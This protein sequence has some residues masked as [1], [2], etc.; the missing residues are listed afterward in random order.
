MNFISEINL[1]KKVNSILKPP[2]NLLVSIWSERYRKLS[3]ETSSEVGKWNTDRTVYQREPMDCISDPE[4]KYL[5]LKFPSQMGKSDIAL[6]I[7]GRFIHLEPCPILVVQPSDKDAE[8]FSQRFSYMIRDCDPLSKLISEPGSRKAKNKISY[9]TFPGGEI[10]FVGSNSPN[11]LSGKPIKLLLCDDIR[12]FP[13]SSGK[14]GDPVDLA[15][16]RT[17]TFFDSLIILSSSP[18]MKGRCRISEAYNLSDQRTY[19]MPCPGCG[20]EIL[21]KWKYLKFEKNKKGN[22]LIASIFYQCYFCNYK[23]DESQKQEMIEAGKWIRNA[24]HIKNSAGFWLTELYSPWVKWEEV[25]RSFLDAKKD[26]EKLKV[27]INTS[28][29]EEYQDRGDIPDWKYL[30]SRKDKYK[31]NEIPRQGLLLVGGADVQKNRIEIEIVIYGRKFESWSIDYRVLTGD[32]TQS[33]IWNLLNDILNE[34]FYHPAGK[35]IRIRRI[36]IDSGH[37]TTNVY[38]FGRKLGPDLVIVGKGMSHLNSIL[39]HPKKMDIDLGNRKI[40]GGV[41]LYGIGERIIKN[42]IY[43]HLRKESPKAGDPFPDGFFHFP[44]DYQEEYFKMLTAEQAKLY[45]TST[46]Y[47]T[48]YEKIRERNEALD[49]RVL[50]RAAASSLGMDSYSDLMWDRIENSLTNTPKTKKKSKTRKRGGFSIKF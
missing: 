13:R 11:N 5:I 28:F 24:K 4:I 33:D 44:Y 50:A 15:K 9:K 39:G 23:I 37:C 48:R 27:V 7:I 26:P 10:S 17:K 34:E 32:P 20:N 47:V 41:H 18:G 12:G 45:K 36:A 19:M 3:P 14:E 6:N 49:C 22:L 8:E 40:Y 2:S 25:I 43:S 1:Q 38:M 35:K 42:E 31:R 29:C 30:F 21:F 46:G 16:N